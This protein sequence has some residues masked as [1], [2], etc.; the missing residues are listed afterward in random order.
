MYKNIDL[1]KLVLIDN[2]STMDIFCNLYLVE[3]MQKVNK[4]LMVQINGEEIYANH[5]AQIPG[6]NKTLWFTRR[7]INNIIALKNLTKK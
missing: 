3:D 4:P 1:S 7:N 5:I 6:Y 2:E